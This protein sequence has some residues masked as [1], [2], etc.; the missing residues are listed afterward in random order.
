MKSL[1]TYSRMVMTR[2]RL[3]WRTWPTVSLPKTLVAVSKRNRE[4]F[5]YYISPSC[6]VGAHYHGH[7][8]G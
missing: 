8:L 3:I 6:L 2:R 4:F 1:L 7:I 5:H